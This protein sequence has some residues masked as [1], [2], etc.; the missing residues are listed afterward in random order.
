MSISYPKSWKGVF[1]PQTPR[2]WC[3]TDTEVARGAD[4]ARRTSADAMWHYGHVARPRMAHARR[5]WRGHVARGHA[6]PPGHLW[7]VPRGEWRGRHLEG[8]QVSGPWLEVWGGNANAL[9]RLSFYIGYIKLFSLCRTMF[10][11]IFLL[12]VTW[13]IRSIG[14]DR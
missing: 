9:P 4:M 12:Q 5:R 2:S 7:G 11:R 14:S 1:I 3:S 8:A 6:G 10:P 13:W